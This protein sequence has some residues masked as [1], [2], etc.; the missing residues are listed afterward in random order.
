MQ[1]TLDKKSEYQEFL[2]GLGTF[3]DAITI[4][5]KTRH[6]IH[7]VWWRDDMAQST[8]NW[9]MDRLNKKIYGRS[10]SGGHKRIAV[11]IAYERGGITGR[12]HFHLA[13]E[14]PS[15]LSKLKFHQ[16]INDVF[17]RLDWKFGTID[18]CNYRSSKFLR[19]ICKGDFER[20]L[21]SVC[22]KG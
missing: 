12:P 9:F 2:N 1:A 13:I 19:Y 21:L 18:I 6:P 17:K 7:H 10:Y 14:R 8:A 4:N 16:L 20:F 3:T 5:L 11:V 22:T 15:Q